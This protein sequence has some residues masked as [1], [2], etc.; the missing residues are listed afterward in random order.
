MTDFITRGPIIISDDNILGL[1]QINSTN[2]GKSSL[3][4]ERN[5]F[6][7]RSSGSTNNKKNGKINPNSS[8][9]EYDISN[10]SDKLLKA[11]TFSTVAIVICLI[12]IIL[13][14]LLAIN[15]RK[16]ELEKMEDLDSMFYI[17]EQMNQYEIQNSEKNNKDKINLNLRT[18]IDS[19]QTNHSNLTINTGSGTSGTS[20]TGTATSIKPELQ[21]LQGVDHP[22]KILPH[23]TAMPL[24]PTPEE[25]N[26]KNQMHGFPPILGS[27][28][29]MMTNLKNLQSIESNAS[30]AK[31]DDVMT[32]LPPSRPPV[33][34]PSYC[35]GGESNSYLFLI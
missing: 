9:T 26:I 21:T 15:R 18:S 25:E 29:T 14:L 32:V 2:L 35:K 16:E 20:G 4:I 1:G 13:S 3:N 33:L 34:G 27:P 22:T 17:K 5:P 7:S 24:P 19:D 28:S 31:S 11:Y 30:S 8:T 10:R 6:N 12:A 23:I